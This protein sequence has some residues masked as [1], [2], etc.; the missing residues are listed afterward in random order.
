MGVDKKS[1]HYTSAQSY[2]DLDGQSRQFTFVDHDRKVML[3]IKSPP[4]KNWEKDYKQELVLRITTISASI[5]PTSFNDLTL[6]G[7][8]EKIEW[9]LDRLYDTGIPKLRTICTILENKNESYG[10]KSTI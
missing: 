8:R 3:D 5:C 6:R 2:T 1:D 4:P 10:K 9:N 7:D